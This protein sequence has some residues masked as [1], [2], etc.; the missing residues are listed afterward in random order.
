MLLT[1]AEIMEKQGS[2]SAGTLK[3]LANNR[4]VAMRAR[5]RGASKRYRLGMGTVNPG[6]PNE[7]RGARHRKGFRYV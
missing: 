5:S 3:K 2:P 6:S 4:L 7:D 1:A